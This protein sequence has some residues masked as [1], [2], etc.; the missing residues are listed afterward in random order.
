M[1]AIRP[2]QATDAPAVTACVVAAYGIYVE[3]MGKP[4][5]PMLDDYAAVITDHAVFVLTDDGAIAG[6]LVLMRQ[7]DGLLLDNVAVHPDLIRARAMA[8]V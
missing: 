7:E 5:G 1:T 2:A 8:A 3:R 6:V 4:P